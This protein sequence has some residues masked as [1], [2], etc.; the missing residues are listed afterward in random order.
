MPIR[1]KVF[2]TKTNQNYKRYFLV[3]IGGSQ[4]SEIFDKTIADAIIKLPNEVL[5]NITL[6]QQVRKEKS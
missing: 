6:F 1:E 2:E 5:E 3:V 4:G